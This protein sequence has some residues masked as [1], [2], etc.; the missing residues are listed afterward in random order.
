MS[1][2]REGGGEVH[3]HSECARVEVV[4][5]SGGWMWVSGGWMCVGVGGGVWVNVGGGE[6]VEVVGG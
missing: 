6:W 1:E 4:G 3:T 5:V 2:I